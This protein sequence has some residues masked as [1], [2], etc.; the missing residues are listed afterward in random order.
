MVY[1]SPLEGF[2]KATLAVETEANTHLGELR[3]L[4]LTIDV[5]DPEINV[6]K[7]LLPQLGQ[8]LVPFPNAGELWFDA[9]PQEIIESEEGRKRT[10][11]VVQP[12]RQLHF[13]NFIFQPVVVSYEQLNK[14]RTVKSNV[15]E[16]GIRSV[17]EG[18][19]IE[20]IQPRDM[21]ISLNAFRP[22]KSPWFL[23][24]DDIFL[25]TLAYPVIIFLGSL[26]ALFLSLA[27]VDFAGRLQ[28]KKPD[29]RANLWKEL[30][31]VNFSLAADNRD[32]WKPNYLA[33]S[34]KL[35]EVLTSCFGVSLYTVDL[36]RCNENFRR[37]IAEL[38]KVYREQ[39]TP[40]TIVVIDGLRTF[41]LYR[42]YD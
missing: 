23:E 29:P 6:R 35:N 31:A 15:A 14:L 37:I 39:D 34:R 7:D 20:D 27:F 36:N 12:F 19:N 33:I 17:I 40:D 4:K 30:E 11:T 13:G 10:I 25:S 16:F 1:W 18:T 42:R 21:D 8:T 5:L 41:C 28:K 22:I 32:N 9:F 3:K 38:N 2:I 26:G 24:G